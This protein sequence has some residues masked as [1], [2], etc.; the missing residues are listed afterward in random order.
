MKGKDFQYIRLGDGTCN[1]L[2]MGKNKANID[3]TRLRHR[4]IAFEK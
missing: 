4:R 1:L 2:K 3:G